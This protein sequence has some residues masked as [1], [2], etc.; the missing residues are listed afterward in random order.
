MEDS[1]LE[2]I[3]EKVIS[4]KSDMLD[5]KFAKFEHSLRN[6][7]VN[8]RNDLNSVKELNKKE[9]SKI[10]ESVNDIEDGQK[11]IEK[12]FEDQIEKI[13]DLIKDNK[14]LFSE[15]QRLHNEIKALYQSQ[16]E[17]QTE[18]NKLAQYNR[19]S[20]MLELSGIPRQD[21]ENAI[22]L[23][24]KNAVVAGICN[25][26][27]SQIDIAH[28]VSQ[29]G[30]APIIFLFNRKTDRANFYIQKKKLFKVRANHIV[31]PNNNEDHSES[32]VCLPGLER[33][34]SYIYMN[35]SLTSM[36]RMLLR[37]ARKESNR[38]KYEFPGYPVNG[39]VRVKKSKSSEYIPINSKH[40][41]ANIT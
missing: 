12:E 28:R 4:K 1:K 10:T 24:N 19:S 6:D 8:L 11:F 39:Q 22:D 20:F 17:N 9:L 18:I 35:K 3:L 30:T 37:E 40:D 26:D 23:V 15:N 13:K 7:I 25:F 34:N 36:N 21:D 41:L 38:L 33:E 14:K 31:K 2:E 5:E 29:K 16:E 27:V 32:E